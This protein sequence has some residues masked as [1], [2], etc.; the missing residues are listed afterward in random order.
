MKVRKERCGDCHWGD[1]MANGR[2]VMLCYRKAPALGTKKDRQWPWVSP[3]DYCGEFKQ[4][5]EPEDND[6]QP[7]QR[8]P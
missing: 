4:S 5:E 8:T 2:G 7:N 3:D 1:Y 6:N